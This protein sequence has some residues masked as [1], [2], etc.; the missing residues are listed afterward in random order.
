MRWI[1]RYLIKLAWVQNF[2]GHMHRKRNF[3]IWEWCHRSAPYTTALEIHIGGLLWIWGQLKSKY[4]PISD[5]MTK[6]CLEQI[7]NEY[8]RIEETLTLSGG[9]LHG[10]LEE[11]T[12]S[13]KAIFAHYIFRLTL[14]K[15]LESLKN[16]ELMIFKTQAISCSWLILFGCSYWLKL[17]LVEMEDREE[18]KR[19]TR[20]EE[21]TETDKHKIYVYIYI[22]VK[23]VQTHTQYIHIFNLITYACYSYIIFTKYILMYT[24][25]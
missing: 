16:L 5:Y 9:N 7:K 15:L 17:S 24:Y 1:I 21:E 2:T 13:W 20:K 12:I 18:S 4:K 25:M 23:L 11:N 10:K 6:H 14:E 3:L 8:I 19:K 22:Y